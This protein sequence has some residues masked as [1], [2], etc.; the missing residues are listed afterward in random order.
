MAGGMA[1]PVDTFVEDGFQVTG[2]MLEA[3]ITPRTKAI[4]INYPNNPTG[5]NPDART[6]AGNRRG[7]GKV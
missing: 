3:S 5:A 6:H 7:G 4:L 2:A 1:V